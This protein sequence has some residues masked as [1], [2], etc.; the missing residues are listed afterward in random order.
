[1]D[2][3]TNS[4][5]QK[6]EKNQNLINFFDLLIQIDRRTNSTLYGPTN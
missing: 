5:E 6:L 4:Q 2:Q 3:E 1:M